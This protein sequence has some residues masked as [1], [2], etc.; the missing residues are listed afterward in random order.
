MGVGKACAH[1]NDGAA[2][3][4]TV[5]SER[6]AAK[7]ERAAPRGAD[8]S[9]ER[10]RARADAQGAAQPAGARLAPGGARRAEGIAR[11]RR[12]RRD[13][14][15]QVDAGASVST[16]GGDGGVRRRAVLGDRDAAATRRRRLPR[17]A[18]RRRARR[19]R[20]PFGWLLDPPRGQTEQGDAHPVLHN[21]HRA[22][23]AAGRRTAQRRLPPD[24]RRGARALGGERLPPDG[25]REDAAGQPHAPRAP[26]VGHAQCRSLLRI[27]WRRA[28]A[29]DPG[30]HLPRHAALF[31]GRHR[32]HA[33]RRP[34]RS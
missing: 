31:G 16:R 25:D 8:A 20:R 3:A 12:V 19:T 24:R 18:R 27:L 14:L 5:G 26:H 28:D 34:Q 4:A 2:A 21:G 11:A 10:A 29:H 1:Q 33:P 17:A 32:A 23:A 15:R 22:A 30:A 7:G 6:G 13:G 9:R